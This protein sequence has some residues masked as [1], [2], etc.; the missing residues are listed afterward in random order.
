MQSFHTFVG[1]DIGANHFAASL[2]TSPNH[3]IKTQDKIPN[4]QDGFQQLLDWLKLNQC[5]AANSVICMEAT[6]VYGECLAYFLCAQG[7]K[8]AVEPPLKVKRAFNPS[9]EKTDAVDSQQI[10]Q[11]AYRFIDQ[12]HFFVPKNEVLEKINVLLGLREQFVIQKSANINS[13]KQLLKGHFPNQEAHAHLDQSI[14]FLA[15]QIKTI[16]T[17][18]K[19]LIDQ[20]PEYKNKISLL[21]SIPSVGL[22]LATNILVLTNGFNKTLNYKQ[23]SAYAGICPK[24]HESGS[25]IRYKPTS[26]GFGP[27]TLRKLL[28]LASMSLRTHNQNSKKYYLRKIAE[29]KAGKLVLNN[30]ANKLL[31]IIF[32]VI[33]NQTQ[34]IPNYQSVHPML[35]QSA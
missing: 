13:K 16:E 24:R 8:V 15:N 18:I 31:K 33:K 19:N 17:Q 7:F 23:L 21:K 30:I 1:I 9:K 14:E 27:H 20:D 22:L 11:Y 34:F 12:L 4:N 28:Y 26:S 3:S 6:G 10:A 35:L 32:A 25:S 29:G 2:F 5:H